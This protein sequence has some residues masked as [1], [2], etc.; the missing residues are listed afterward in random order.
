MS[1]PSSMRTLPNGEIAAYDG[2]A[3]YT[4]CED[5]PGCCPT[6]VVGDD[7]VVI[8]TDDGSSV[9]LTRKEFRKLAGVA[10]VTVG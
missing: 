10:L 2:D 3:R 6:V 1:T 7:D 9:R 5:P 8:T 4:L